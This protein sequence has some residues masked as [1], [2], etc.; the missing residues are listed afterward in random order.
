MFFSGTSKKRLIC[1]VPLLLT[2]LVIPLSLLTLAGTGGAL[3]DVGSATRAGSDLSRAEYLFT[4]LRVIV[5]YIR[6]L[7]LPVNQ[8]LAYDYPVYRTLFTPP[9]FLSFLFLLA[10]F[11]LAVYLTYRSRFKVQGSR[12]EVQGSA[13]GIQNSPFYRLTAFGIFWFFL[14]L[15]VESS[16]IPITDVI[17]EHR[18]YLPSVGAFLAFACCFVAAG[19]KLAARVSGGGTAAIALAGLIVLALTA[20]SYARNQVWGSQESLWQDVVNKSPGKAVGYQYLGIALFER[21]EVERAFASFDRSLA[22]DPLLDG[23]YINRGSLNAR[24]GRYQQ[25]IADLSRAVDLDPSSVEAWSNL[26]LTWSQLGEQDK[27]IASLSRAIALNPTY[28]KA[29]NNMGLAFIRKGAPGE[30]IPYLDKAL[31][32]N[33][34]YGLAWFN[35]GVAY[36]D[37][38]RLDR[39]IA[40]LSRA[41][42]LNPR[43]GP[44]YSHRGAALAR[45]G[46]RERALAD[47]RTAC[48]NGDENGCGE[49]RKLTGR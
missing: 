46:A 22:I 5:T 20:A 28:L 1:L 27:A 49:L 13:L 23:A 25:A 24:V 42:E 19:Q 39:A 9:V 44:A 2:M 15:S 48:E 16:I 36:K 37:T 41:I 33:R 40:D 21:G 35:R 47:F 10:L 30:A 11:G 32:L 12:F 38:G 14:T 8:N 17:F 29:L 43:F 3:G 18:L 26:G 6:L 34:N 45:T 31:A 7:F 4:E